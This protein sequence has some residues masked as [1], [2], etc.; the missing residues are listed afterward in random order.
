MDLKCLNRKN[1]R[2]FLECQK[3]VSEIGV[4][5][6]KLNLLRQKVATGDISTSSWRKIKNNLLYIQECHQANKKMTLKDNQPTS[7]NTFPIMNSL[8]ISDLDLISKEKDCSEYWNS[9]SQEISKKLWL[10]IETDFVD[11]VS[12]SSNSSLRNTEPF[13][14]SLKMKESKHLSMNLQKTS[15]QSLQFSQPD[16]MDQENIIYCKKIRIYPTKEQVSLFNKCLGA[17]RYFYNKANHFIKTKYQESLNNANTEKERLINKNN[18]CIMILKEGNQCCK[19]KSKDSHLCKSH[20]KTYKLKIDYS[21]LSRIKIRDNILVPDSKLTEEDVWQKEIP[22]DTRQ[23]AIDQVLAVYKSNFALI[24]NRENKEFNITFKS[25]KELT[26]MFQINKKAINFEKLKVFSTRLN[27]KIRV[28]N[29]DLDLLKEG[30]DGNITCIKTKPNN[31]YLCIPKE[32]NI[33]VFKNSSYKSVFLDPGVRTFQTFYSPDGICGKIGDDF[34]NK[35]IKNK[36]E[37]IDKLESIRSSSSCKTKRNI[38]NRLFKIRNKIKNSI[39]DLHWKTCNFLCSNFD[40]IFLPKFKTSEMVEKTPKRVISK[41][42]VRQM[43]ELSHCE[44]REKLNYYAKTKSKNLVLITEGY[45]TKTCGI[46]GKQNNVGSLKVY[47]CS[48]GYKID[49]DYHGA[50]NICIRTLS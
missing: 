24:K 27:K 25:K 30:T 42:T 12:N 31:W 46:C 15:Y 37:K 6:E 16:I 23:F 19:E 33:P 44:F 35:F 41:K 21:Y 38:R 48:C 28:R 5:K 20:L 22:Y 32:K 3:N 43:L 47:E 10:P 34:C 17:N 8:Q 29:R 36:T 11:L 13:L 7:K 9:Y 45:T 2:H 18:G 1:F 50:R 39:K 4:S 49:R 14:Q 26:Q 40:T